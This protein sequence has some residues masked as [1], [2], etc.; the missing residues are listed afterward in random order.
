MSRVL[1]FAALAEAL[2][3]LAFSLFPRWSANYCLVNTW[4]ESQYRLPA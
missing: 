3:G 2:T 1:G 4:Q